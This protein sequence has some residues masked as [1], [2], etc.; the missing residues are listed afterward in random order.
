[1]RI[2]ERCAGAGMTRW[3]L[4]VEGVNFSSTLYDT[5]DL[6][7]VR[8]ASIALLQVEKV[9]ED[10]ADRIGTQRKAVFAGASQAAVTFIAPAG[11]DVPAA[12]ATAAEARLSQPGR[13]EE[14]FPHLDII[15]QAV[16]LGTEG[17]AEEVALE[18]ATALT[19]LRQFKRFTT[20]PVRFEPNARHAD[21]LDGFRPAT[22]ELKNRY[23]LLGSANELARAKPLRVSQS[24]KARKAYGRLAR[25]AFYRLDIALGEKLADEVLREK[26][27]DEVLGKTGVGLTFTDD[28]Q[29]IVER[30]RDP[31][32]PFS[33]VALPLQIQNKIAVIYADGN[34]FGAAR[35]EIN[36][37]AEFSA[38]VRPLQRKLLARLLRRLA[39]GAFESKNEAFALREG[40]RLGLRFETLLWGGDEMCF[41]MPAWLAIG[42]V[43]AFLS[44]DPW[45]VAGV[46]LT[47]ALGVA[48]ADR[49]TP[50]RQL[51]YIAKTSADAAKEADLRHCNSVTF[52]IFESL[53]PPDD[54]LGRARASLFG[55]SAR[56]SNFANQLAFKGD[57]Y[58]ELVKHL[59]RITGANGFPRSQIYAA[60]RAARLAGGED[61]L[62][63]EAQ[64]ASDRSLLVYA[65]R[66]GRDGEIK[67]EELRLPGGKPP[68]LSAASA[69]PSVLDLARIALL[70]DYVS[71][72]PGILDILLPEAL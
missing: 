29:A 61:L 31:N 40:Q 71:P 62:G 48:I 15:V 41:V 47:H 72:Q 33:E 35:E 45:Q 21:D 17:N 11:L 36:S 67:V 53:A 13:A 27:E 56:E 68:V 26:P 52:D 28:L 49:K 64:A 18:R 1:M 32:S 20:P 58:L 50:I 39:K 23:N 46:K 24:V 65:Q 37:T 16:P 19:R 38:K 12:V 6:S 60:L 8:G 34:G 43:G 14:P 63:R 5:N 69:P 2:C 25:Q 10:I 44:E 42:F 9:A 54:D 7:T 55:V 30:G 59:T 66:A 51:Q 4:R 70:W 3:L 22:A 57:H